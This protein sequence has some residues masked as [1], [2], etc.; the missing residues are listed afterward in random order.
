[1]TYG[2]KIKQHEIVIPTDPLPVWYFVFHDHNSE[3]YIAPHWHRGIELSYVENGRIDDFLINKKHYSSQSGTILVVNTQ[4]IHS[5][6]D[7][8][9]TDSLALSIIF[10]YDYIANLYPDIAHQVIKI[11]DPTMFSNKQK[12]A[13]LHL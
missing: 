7:F 5:I 2:K 8:R 10:P 1:M 11:N 4:E 9:N 13:Y 12:L 3:K 6:H